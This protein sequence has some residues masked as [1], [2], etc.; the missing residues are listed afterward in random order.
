[1]HHVE[2]VEL[3]EGGDVVVFV[4]F[5]SPSSSSSSFT[6][7]QTGGVVLSGHAI[8]FAHLSA[9]QRLDTFVYHRMKS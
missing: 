5:I 8:V 9:Y 7:Y 4:Y 1:M 6:L 2:V 3:E